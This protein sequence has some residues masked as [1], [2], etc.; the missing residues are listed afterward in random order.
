MREKLPHSTAS[1]VL[2][3]FSIIT[4][5]CY[6]LP[7]IILGIIGFFQGRKAINIDMEEPGVYEGLS[8]AKAG[9]ITSIIGI[10][11]GVVF[12]LLIFF[13]INSIG[14]WDEFKELMELY[15]EDPEAFQERVEELQN[16]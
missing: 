15:T 6:G 4:C 11:L 8:N 10:I 1:L 12:I 5:W 2:G 16:R 7:G 14:G 9:K 3:I 13:M